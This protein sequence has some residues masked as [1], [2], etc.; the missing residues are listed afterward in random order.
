MVII[1]LI[2][3]KCIPVPSTE[4]KFN[5]TEGIIGEWVHTLSSVDKTKIQISTKFPNFS[6]KLNYLRKINNP[7]ISYRELKES[8]VSSLK[9]LNIDCVETFFYSLA[10]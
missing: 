5:L 7:S 4:E 10:L 6:K 1:N 8:L 9:R 2:Q 3:H